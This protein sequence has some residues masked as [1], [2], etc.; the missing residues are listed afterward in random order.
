MDWILSGVTWRWTE[1]HRG[2][3][4]PWWSETVLGGVLYWS[5][6][7][8]PYSR[9][10]TRGA[11]KSPQITPSVHPFPAYQPRPNLSLIISTRKIPLEIGPA[12]HILWKF[13]A[14][15]TKIRMCVNSVSP[16]ATFQIALNV[17][18]FD[19]DKSGNGKPF[20]FLA[21]MNKNVV[22]GKLTHLS[23]WPG[24]A[25]LVAVIIVLSRARLMGGATNSSLIA[26]TKLITGQ[27][28]TKNQRKY[29]AVTIIT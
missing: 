20:L 28:W 14:V 11:G 23:R 1:S 21:R 3:L 22:S 4:G 13:T 9:Q 6:H 8:S 7:I 10:I 19:I 24:S 12:S 2:P 18:V 29:M 25:P 27:Q 17:K 26:S 15:Q 16:N 5:G